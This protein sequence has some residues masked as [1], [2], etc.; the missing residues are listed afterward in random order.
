MCIYAQDA[1]PLM[2]VCE[3]DISESIS[4]LLLDEPLV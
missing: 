2:Y 3:A 1:T 4:Y